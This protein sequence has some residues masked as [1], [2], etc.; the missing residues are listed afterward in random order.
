MKAE[1][2]RQIDEYIKEKA[3]DKIRIETLSKMLQ[4]GERGQ[5]EVIEK[6]KKDIADREGMKRQIEILQDK[7]ENLEEELE[8][9]KQ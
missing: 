6:F 7:I 9:A 1:Y 3:M 4:D 8:N 5:G 2:Q